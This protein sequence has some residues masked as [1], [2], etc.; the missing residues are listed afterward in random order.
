MLRLTLVLFLILNSPSLWALTEPEEES[1]P[2]PP[3]EINKWQFKS[4][5]D[6]FTLEKTENRY[7]I[8]Q[9]EVNPVVFSD[10]EQIFSANTEYDVGCP[11]DLGK[12]PTVTITAYG[13]DNQPYVREFFVEKGYV[14]DRQNNKCLFIMKEGL[15]RLPLH[16]SCFIGQTNASLPIKNKLQVYYNGKLLYDFEKVNNNWQQNVKNLFINWEYFQRV[17]EAFKDFP[18]D[19]RY[20]PAIANEKKTFEIRTGR[21]VYSFYLTGRNFWA[22]KI[23]KVNWLVASSA[24][25][26]FEDFN[27][28]LWLSRYHDQLLNLTNK[29]LPYAQRT[30]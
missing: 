1:P 29:D 16:R 6:N 7:T 12:K 26:L 11:H 27:P 28:S 5:L 23:P 25:A 17:L 8:G 2:A 19:Q 14:R 22:A 30:S 18:I 3:V 24:W 10:F 9:R 15:T 21:E 13:S 4:D 20:H